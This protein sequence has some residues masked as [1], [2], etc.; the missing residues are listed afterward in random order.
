MVSCC[1]YCNEVVS[2]SC[3]QL[4]YVLAYVS[5]LYLMHLRT[6]QQ[7][8]RPPRQGFWL[9]YECISLE[10]AIGFNPDFFE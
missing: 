8:R 6:L 2:T 5:F 3:F 10:N 9:V 1:S 7:E 4:A